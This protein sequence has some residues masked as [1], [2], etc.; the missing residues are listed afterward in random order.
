MGYYLALSF[1]SSELIVWSVC[2]GFILGIVA[3]FVIKQVQGKFI[4][5]LLEKGANDEDSAVSLE[6]LGQGS[7]KF[8]KLCLKVGSGIRG[9]VTFVD[10][11]DAKSPNFEVIR[12]Y[13]SEDRLEKATSMTKGGMKWYFLPIFSILI[14]I[15]TIIVIEL[16]PVLTSF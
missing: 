10:E 6:D 5:L 13:V 2:V 15:I 14:V 16:L 1:D 11:A 8:L 7:N 3:T 9:I 4:S 12:F